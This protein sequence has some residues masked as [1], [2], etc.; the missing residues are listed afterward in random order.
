MAIEASFTIDEADFPLS[1]VFAQL[2]DATIELDRIVPTSNAIIPYF[3]I[4][5]DDT[6]TFTTD[7]SDDIGV[8]QVSIIDEVEGQMFV[9]VD[10][11]LDHES[12]LTAIVNTDV[13]LLSGIGNKKQWTF[14]V[15]A[16]EQRELS[17]FQT[18]CQKHDIPIELTQLHALASL[19]S[20]RE[21]DLT[22]GQREA[23]VLGYSKGYFDT[24]RTASQDDLAG[25][26]GISRQ[27]VSS[28]LQR[29]LRRLVASALITPEE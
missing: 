21:Y 25:E 12:V 28:R 29:G 4:Y 18:Y 7:L 22:E 20:D 26:L 14:E 3:W 10:W 13:A 27:A 8:D 9:R 23:L 11:N 5:A 16:N 1:A 15:R 24:P 17:E 19:K 6:A 2:T